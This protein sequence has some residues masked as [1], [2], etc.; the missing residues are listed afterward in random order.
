MKPC[1]PRQRLLA[2]A[3]A[4]PL[5]RLPWNH[6]RERVHVM[7]CGSKQR[8][9]A[10]TMG[11]CAPLNV[12]AKCA[13]GRQGSRIC[14]RDALMLDG[15]NF[16]MW[17]LRRLTSS[18]ATNSIMWVTTSTQP[19]SPSERRFTHVEHLPDVLEVTTYP[20]SVAH[21]RDTIHPQ[22]CKLQHESVFC[23]PIDDASSR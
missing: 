8:Q 9:D 3:S 19:T 5:S 21:G 13:P 12:H 16:L 4:C 15:I 14:S 7:V 6:N 18:E 10:E 22:T 23:M 11:S 20:G 2:S 1:G 17:F